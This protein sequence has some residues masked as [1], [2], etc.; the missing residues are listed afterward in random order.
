[1]GPLLETKLFVPRHRGPLVARPRL[2][3]RL[4]RLATL[5]LVSAPPGFGKSTLLAFEL[6][7]QTD[8]QRQ[9][10]WLS[11][12]ANDNTPTAFWTYLIAAL[13][14][15]AS[16][17]GERALALLELNP[18]PLD[19]VPA[20]LINDLATLAGNLVVVL[21]DYHVVD[22][23]D[24]H[25]GVSLL[26]DHLPPQVSLVI[27]S[28]ADPPFPLARLRAR[29]E[30]LEI[31]AADLQFTP[32]EALA[33]LNEVMHLDLT[34][35]D[36]AL[37]ESRTEGWIAALQLAALSMQG[38]DDAAGFIASFAGDDRYIVDYLVEE[39][40]QRQP[41]QLRQFLLETSILDRLSGPLCDA[42][43]EGNAGKST[44]EVL[45]R[46]NLFVVSLDDR[47]RWYRYHH[48]FADVLRTHLR[49][50][51]PQ[52]VS[53]LH[54]RASVWFE[55][56]GERAEAI[57]HALAAV[58]FPRAAELLELEIPALRRSRQETTLRNWL[59]ALPDDVLRS[60]PVLSNMYAG[61]L[62][63]SGQLEGVDARLR[64][65]ERW[66]N[67]TAPE[68]STA[69]R[70]VVDEE[71][72]RQLAGAVAVHRAG[73]ALARGEAA[74]SVAHARRALELA[75]EDDHLA[76]GGAAGLLGLVAWGSG[77][78]DTAEGMYAS[79]IGSLR[80]AD[81]VADTF[82]LSIARA[83]IR[84]AQGRLGAAMQVFEEALR[85]G[86]GA[87]R[88]IADVYVGMSEVHRER[89]E[90]DAARECLRRSEALGDL[91]GMPQNRYR[92][93][94]ALGRLREAE[95]DLDAAVHL[96]EEA[97]RVYVADFFPNVRPVPARR[98]RVL[99]RQGR[100]AEAE[101]WAHAGGVAVDNELSYVR[102]FE[103][104]TLARILLARGMPSDALGLLERLLC[105][106]KDGARAGSAIE[107]LVLES[108]AH[109]ALGSRAAA[110]KPLVRALALAEPERHVRVFL[111]EGPSILALLRLV[112]NE[113]A[114]A[115]HLLGAAGESPSRMSSEA[116]SVEA[117]S[118]RELDVLRLLATELDGPEI[119][120]EL[121]V[122][123]NTVRSHTKNIYSKLGVNNRMAAVRRAEELNL[124][125]RTHQR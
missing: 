4:Q 99:V 14:K 65:A 63:A 80:R 93:R 36:V 6:A 48:L 117:L 90:L 68:A 81:H 82:G 72:F 25:A 113:R 74:E 29:G 19:T 49:E 116:P 108:L 52:R 37:L 94:I 30:L 11:L 7:R 95:G 73:Y 61:A 111:D 91:A 100:L 12:D 89:N 55:Q 123:L 17:V 121:V 21:D 20:A 83:E 42:V 32:D 23:R 77:E 87:V 110:Q 45:D 103:H 92:S 5:T 102:E 3:E 86:A 75:T 78:L 64:D 59:A 40:L 8:P 24:I 76:R 15:V 115:R 107:I 47:R 98:A 38:R 1:V 104:L 69:D 10:A 26:V 28:R 120:R 51:A 85:L 43:T 114:F 67:P 88:G 53:D 27:A 119:A 124:L 54:R 39:V 71:Q 22:N 84:L 34:S 31:R 2:A 44:L 13:Q 58:D 9:V 16:D 112:A 60:R 35:Q 70:V 105:A 101:A 18:P 79:A 56:N 41:E 62:L 106:A 46:A 118:H 66:L 122:S 97:E 57:R 96:L 125:P 33:Y 50:E 109:D